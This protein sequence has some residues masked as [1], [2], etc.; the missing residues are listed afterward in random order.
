MWTISLVLNHFDLC[1]HTF[2]FNH[3]Y[4][5]FEVMLFRILFRYKKFKM[6]PSDSSTYMAATNLSLV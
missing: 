2:Q 5:V 3:F 1:V 4:I 6:L